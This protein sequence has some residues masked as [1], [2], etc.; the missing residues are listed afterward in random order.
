MT[1]SFVTKKNWNNPEP[2]IESLRINY[3]DL[4]LLSN[5]EI[6]LLD[7]YYLHSRINRFLKSIQKRNVYVLKDRT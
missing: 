3:E 6:K 4:P 5:E 1:I 2:L 7:D